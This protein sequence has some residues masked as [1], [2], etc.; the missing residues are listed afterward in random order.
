MKNFYILIS[1]LNFRVLKMA[2][3]AFPGGICKIKISKERR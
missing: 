3:Q 2:C 1:N